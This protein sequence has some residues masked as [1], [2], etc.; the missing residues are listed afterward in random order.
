[1]VVLE[2]STFSHFH[3]STFLHQQITGRYPEGKWVLLY[4]GDDVNLVE[5]N[6]GVEDVE[7]GVI[8]SAC[9]DDVFEELK[10]VGVVDFPLNGDVAHDYRLMELGSVMKEVAVVS[11]V[12]WEIWVIC[13]RIEWAVCH[14]CKESQHSRMPTTPKNMSS[15]RI[16]S[17]IV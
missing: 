10:S 8:Q 16:C 17:Y 15:S 12:S 14:K 6:T 11:F 4:V 7:C 1:M 3:Q 5:D 9:E 2:D 13:E